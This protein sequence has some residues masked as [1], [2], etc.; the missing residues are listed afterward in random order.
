MFSPEQ[1]PKQ[2][3]KHVE[4]ST[5]SSAALMNGNSQAIK[6]PQTRKRNADTTPESMYWPARRE[7]G[8]TTEQDAHLSWVDTVLNAYEESRTGFP[9]VDRAYKV[10]TVEKCPEIGDHLSYMKLPGISALKLLDPYTPGPGPA[11]TV[12]SFPITL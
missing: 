2:M 8:S 4:S 1:L 6:L 11:P 12:C 5:I 9:A 3:E 10:S 7:A